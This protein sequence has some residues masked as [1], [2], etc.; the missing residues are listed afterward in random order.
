[1]DAN[2]N[3]EP[4]DEIVLQDQPDSIL[5]SK[6]KY[7]TTKYIDDNDFGEQ[8]KR[9]L[10]SKFTFKEESIISTLNYI[11]NLTSPIN[12]FTQNRID[13]TRGGE[14][15]IF[16]VINYENFKNLFCF[17]HVETG[18]P[19]LTGIHSIP[20]ITTES[21]SREINNMLKIHPL[22]NNL[23][24]DIQA[25]TIV[26]EADASMHDR[27]IS[28]DK[29]KCINKKP[30]RCKNKYRDI[31]LLSSMNLN[32][33]IKTSNIDMLALHPLKNNY[34]LLSEDDKTKIITRSPDMEYII[35]DTNYVFKMTIGTNII[36]SN[37][38]R[39]I[40]KDEG[41]YSFFYSE[42]VLN[43]IIKMKITN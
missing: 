12:D 25:T 17:T 15:N 20:K 40:Q 32:Q 19:G 22:N 6:F 31:H 35:R 8:K 28:E 18:L 4:E 38:I 26:Q 39:I 23:Y 16:D 24:L 3:F 14:Y 36:Q 37:P 41:P 29:L 5:N 33:L 2:D 34:A 7:P 43:N 11:R 21:P 1:M 30:F 27:E 42:I 13:N 9:D 10:I